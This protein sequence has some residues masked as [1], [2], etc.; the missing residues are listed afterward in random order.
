MGF[1]ALFFV[2]DTME[3]CWRRKRTFR[4][5][6]VDKRALIPVEAF[7][8]RAQRKK[9]GFQSP[10]AYTGPSHTFNGMYSLALS[11]LLFGA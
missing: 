9:K 4:W 2:S 10:N 3:A 8:V 7:S 5:M 6:A 11:L 1:L